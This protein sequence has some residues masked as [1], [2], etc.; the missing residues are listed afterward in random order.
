M[1]FLGS[2]SWVPITMALSG[3]CCSR[4]FVTAA[5]NLCALVLVAGIFIFVA[6]G[7]DFFF[8]LSCRGRSGPCFFSASSKD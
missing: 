4:I 3:N 7:A 8:L 1:C 5:V 6:L 2:P